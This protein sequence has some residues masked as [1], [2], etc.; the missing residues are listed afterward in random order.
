MKKTFFL[1]LYLIGTSQINSQIDCNLP[2]DVTISN[3]LVSNYSSN[4]FSNKVIKIVGTFTVDQNVTMNNCTFIMDGSAS[5]ELTNDKSIIINSCK[6]GCGIWYGIYGSGYFYASNSYFENFTICFDMV[7]SASY[8]TNNTFQSNGTGIAI[9]SYAASGQN[10]SSPP[11]LENL[12]SH[13]NKYQ[14]CD[15]GVV[16]TNCPSSIFIEDDEFITCNFG[17]NADNSIFSV[18]NS[19][20]LY[21]LNG[22][23]LKN[24]SVLNCIGNTLETTFGFCTVG[25]NMNNSTALIKNCKFNLTELGISSCCDSDIK[26][27]NCLFDNIDFNSSIYFILATSTKLRAEII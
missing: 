8:F 16:I 27:E 24:K 25:V 22:I 4:Y 21:C 3:G 6:F 17:I 23:G 19:S 18:F 20:F 15:K 11:P 26:A 13:Q 5:I 9:N 14:Q 1:L 7:A 10:L 12:F 2:I